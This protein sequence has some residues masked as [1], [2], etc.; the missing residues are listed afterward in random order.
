M[1]AGRFL[2][3]VE[4]YAPG[5]STL[6]VFVLSGDDGTLRERDKRE[7]S[8][9][10]GSVRRDPILVGT[11]LFVTTDRDA[12]VA[13]DL[14]GEDDER[15]VQAAARNIPPVAVKTVPDAPFPVASTANSL[16]TVGRNVRFYQI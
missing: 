13:F 15:P 2:F 14:G 11:R 12:F 5:K 8:Q 7:L 4:N 3:A 9:L 6:R 16:W 10:P 1:L